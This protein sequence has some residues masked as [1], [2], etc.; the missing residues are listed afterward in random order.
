[1]HSCVIKGLAQIVLPH[2]DR[3]AEHKEKQVKDG[4]ARKYILLGGHGAPVFLVQVVHHHH[5]DH[6]THHRQAKDQAQQK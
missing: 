1:M 4:E 3:C 6:E 5:V 2:L